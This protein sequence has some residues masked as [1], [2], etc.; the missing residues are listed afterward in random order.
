MTNLNIL[1]KLVDAVSK[2]FELPTNSIVDAKESL[3]EVLK[4]DTSNVN[5]DKLEDL[6]NKVK[7]LTS[8]SV[9]KEDVIYG[10]NPKVF[11]LTGPLVEKARTAGDTP[12]KVNIIEPIDDKLFIVEKQVTV[13]QPSTND[14]NSFK[15]DNSVY[16]ENT[17]TSTF[18]A[19]T[20]VSAI[21]EEL[22]QLKAILDKLKEAINS[23]NKELEELKVKKITLQNEAQ[24]NALEEVRPEDI[25]TKLNDPNYELVYIGDD[26]SKVYAKPKDI[27][28]FTPY[29]PPVA[30]VN[31]REAQFDAD[32]RV[33]SKTSEEIN[34]L[35]GTDKTIERYSL[36]DAIEYVKDGIR[37]IN[38]V[39]YKGEQVYKTIENNNP[40]YIVLKSNEDIFDK[41]N[42]VDKAESID[43]LTQPE[44]RD[45]L[46]S[47]SSLTLEEVKA[48]KNDHDNPYRGKIHKVTK[49]EDK[50]YYIEVLSDE[51]QFDKRYGVLKNESMA[52]LIREL[53]KDNSENAKRVV[54]ET[55]YNFSEIQTKMAE[56]DVENKYKVIKVTGG[57]TDAGYYLVRAYTQE[58]KDLIAEELALSTQGLEDNDA[59]DNITNMVVNKYKTSTMNKKSTGENSE[60]Y[61]VTD[62]DYL[63]LPEYENVVKIKPSDFNESDPKYYL[64]KQDNSGGNVVF[65][66][67]FSG[68]NAPLVVKPEVI[69]ALNKYENTLSNI[70][71]Y[72]D[73]ALKPYTLAKMLL[74][75]TDTD[76]NKV[77]S[78]YMADGRGNYYTITKEEK[79]SK[80]LPSTNVEYFYSSHDV[81]YNFLSHV[82]DTAISPFSNSHLVFSDNQI[83]KLIGEDGPFHDRFVEFVDEDPM[84]ISTDK[85][86]TTRW[87]AQFEDAPL[88]EDNVDKYGFKDINGNKIYILKKDQPALTESDIAAARALVAPKV[89][90]ELT[91]AQVR[92]VL[93]RMGRTNINDIGVE[94][95]TSLPEDVNELNKDYIGT[96]DTDNVYNINIADGRLAPQGGKINE[97]NVRFYTTVGIKLTAGDIV[98]LAKTIKDRDISG[99]E[100]HYLLDQVI[101]IAGENPDYN[102]L[103][104][105]EYAEVVEKSSKYNYLG[106]DNLDDKVLPLYDRRETNNNNKSKIVVVIK[107]EHLNDED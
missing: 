49:G 66:P 23:S 81:K 50:G 39:I 37:G 32:N 98:E 88:N 56:A 97:Y 92:E 104:K 75:D 21:K 69:E 73:H 94:A 48:L 9:S 5:V 4:D 44:D 84:T 16:K 10:R 34:Q 78:L 22:R 36:F 52:A 55:K 67:A 95:K 62:V 1:T 12:V 93:T 102:D 82:R 65:P 42:N 18:D 107:E 83:A 47:T 28:T 38:G 80:K 6:G 51:A 61:V 24:K 74:D 96:S 35:A 70:Y 72:E 85:L 91:D 11:E 14:S 7:E 43:G 15:I 53:N 57:S 64:K 105:F 71:E 19:D 8:N 2:K 87:A 86:L 45:T 54:I 89:N 30:K 63:K 76:R 31:A 17:D 60:Y 90:K 79:A 58:E 26:R 46:I 27:K 25:A 100:A 59:S 20:T 3:K 33:Q 41:K 103:F 40:V 101:S 13:S 106:T 77:A 68:E 29:V 99:L